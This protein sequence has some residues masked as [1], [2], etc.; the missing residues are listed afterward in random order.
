M[1]MVLDKNEQTCHRSNGASRLGKEVSQHDVE[2]RDEGVYLGPDSDPD[3]YY[4]DPDSDSDLY[5]Y[6]FDCSDLGF[7]F[8]FLL[9]PL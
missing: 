5:Y 6:H 1:K 8:D 3:F 9:F 2:S 7:D 4:S